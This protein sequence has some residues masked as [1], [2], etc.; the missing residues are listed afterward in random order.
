MEKKILMLVGDFVEDYE[1]APP[2][3][4]TPRRPR[5]HRHNRTSGS[6]GREESHDGHD[7]V[8]EEIPS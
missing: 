2:G 8:P 4:V 7:G 5:R 3:V 1:V 6:G